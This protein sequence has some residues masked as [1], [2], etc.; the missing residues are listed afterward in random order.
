MVAEDGEFIHIIPA[1]NGRYKIQTLHSDGD[2]TV[3]EVLRM[4]EEKKLEY[5]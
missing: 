2:K 3:E 5:I 1:K 4:C